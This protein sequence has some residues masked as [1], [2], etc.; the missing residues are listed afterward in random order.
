MLKKLLWISDQ[1]MHAR[2]AGKLVS[3]A[4]EYKSEISLCSENTK[5]DAKGLFS[6]MGLILKKGDKISLSVNGEDEQIAFKDI[7]ELLVNENLVEKD[8]N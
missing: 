1:S 7:Y 5:A 2:P 3:K 4:S 6:L 8:T